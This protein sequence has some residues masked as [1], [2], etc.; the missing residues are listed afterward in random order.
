MTSIVFYFQ[1]HQ[2]YRVKA[3]PYDAIGQRHD[4]FDDW[5][6]EDV[7]K[8]VAELCYLPMNET[9]LRAIGR[10]DGAFRCAFSISGTALRQL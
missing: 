2:P 1:V 7:T 3:Y 9:L 4:Y 5:L 10:A 8:R 6:N